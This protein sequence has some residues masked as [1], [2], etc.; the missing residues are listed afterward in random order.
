MVLP[1]TG[2]FGNRRSCVY[3]LYGLTEEDIEIVESKKGEVL[4]DLGIPSNG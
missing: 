1:K 3:Q 2:I 4:P